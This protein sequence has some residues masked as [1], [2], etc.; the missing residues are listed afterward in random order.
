MRSLADF[1]VI[2]IIDDNTPYPALLGIEWAFENQA[3]INLKKKTMSFEGNGIQVIGPLDLALGLRYTELI[4]AKEEARNI[5]TVYQL[6]ASQGDYVNP[7][8]DGML[9]W[10]CEISCVSDSEVGLENWQQ[11]LHEFSGRR[12]ARITKSLRW[13]GS[14]VSTLP[15]FD[16]LLDIQ[17]FVQEYEAQVP[18]SERL[19][20]LVVVLRATPTRWWTTH[21]GN[22]ATWDTCRRLLMIRF[23]ANIG[24]MDSLYDGVSC[25]TPHIWACEE[26]WKD[27]SSD[28]CVH[29]F[30]HTLD[31]NPG[32]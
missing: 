25:P 3:I 30:V 12:L 8:D 1:K 6:T 9:S 20:Y 11:C 32:H 2:E 7:I 28:E 29:L 21:Q 19:Q 16:G 27:R 4:I 18:C 17:I 10:R 26:A 24:G 5:D 14:E 15:I 22:I 31:S 13:I 23:G